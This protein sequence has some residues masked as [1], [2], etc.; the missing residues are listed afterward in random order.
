M[1]QKHACTHNTLKP[2]KLKS[3]SELSNEIGT[4]CSGRNMFRVPT[5]LNVQIKTVEETP[6]KNK[7]FQREK[8]IHHSCLDIW[9][10]LLH[11]LIWWEVLL[12]QNFYGRA[13]CYFTKIKQ[14]KTTIYALGTW[15]NF[16][17]YIYIYMELK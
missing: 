8:L 6:R 11:T 15:T 12:T 10:S 7:E 16:T 2:T 14:S 17:Y 13:Y 3:R 1:D 4:L 5:S 9:F